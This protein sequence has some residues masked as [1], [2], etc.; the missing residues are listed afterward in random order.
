MANNSVLLLG[1]IDGDHSVMRE[2]FRSTMPSKPSRI[3]ARDGTSSK[4]RFYIPTCR[5][6][7]M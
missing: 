5:M 1:C 7:V 4:A 3:R 6:M 2:K